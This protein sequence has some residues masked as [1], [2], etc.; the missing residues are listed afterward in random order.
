MSLR[1]RKY[2]TI[3]GNK[4]DNTGCKMIYFD[5]W[6]FFIEGSLNYLAF[7]NESLFN[8]KFAGILKLSVDK[9]ITENIFAALSYKLGNSSPT[10]KE[11][12]SAELGLKMKFF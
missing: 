6:K 2:K 4:N 12:N 1:L 5:N 3:N 7:E 9:R 11:Y 10:Y 8:D